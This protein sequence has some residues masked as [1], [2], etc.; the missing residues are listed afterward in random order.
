MLGGLQWLSL[1]C[2]L[3]N[4]SSWVW[5]STLG[6]G[7]ALGL[8]GVAAMLLLNTDRNSAFG[9]SGMVDVTIF[10]ALEG[11]LIGGVWSALTGRTVSKWQLSS[12]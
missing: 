12:R 4:V 2:R 7:I 10:V 6:F 11:L 9:W 8:V 5:Q 3:E 1:R